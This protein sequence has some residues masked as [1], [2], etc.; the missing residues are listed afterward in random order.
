MQIE[1]WIDTI[2]DST[3]PEEISIMQQNRIMASWNVLTQIFVYMK[4]KFIS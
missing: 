3:G 4:H 1:I 2:S